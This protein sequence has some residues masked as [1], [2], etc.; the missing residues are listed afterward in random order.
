MPRPKNY[1]VLRG[2]RGT[3][4]RQKLLDTFAGLGEQ[5]P[6]GAPSNP[7]PASVPLYIEPWNL[8]LGDAIQL[9]VSA[10]LPSWQALGAFSEVSTR[11]K[12]T[13]ASGDTSIKLKNYQPPRIVRTIQTGNT[14]TVQRSKRT[15]LS[16]I[17]YNKDS[18]SVPLGRKSGDT[19]LTNAFNQVRTQVT[20][21]QANV[22][23][24]LIEEN[25]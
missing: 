16:Y 11:T 9:Q 24:R 10:L 12:N 18:V 4:A 21:G 13:L 19:S 25:I 14:G 2:A 22:K 6:V 7:R 23:V 15:G 8:T 5:R 20:A 1:W 17:K 3:A